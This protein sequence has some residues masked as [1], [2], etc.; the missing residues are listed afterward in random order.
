M[1]EH[2]LLMKFKKQIII[3]I[4]EIVGQFYTQNVLQ[5]IWKAQLGE[6]LWK[7]MLARYK[8]SGFI[9]KYTTNSDTSNSY[10]SH[11]Q[12]SLKL[13]LLICEILTVNEKHTKWATINV[14]LLIKLISLPF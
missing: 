10:N 7:V 14:K 4:L 2:K 9:I 5:N 1:L 3:K 12:I 11:S 13:M 8:V 6:K